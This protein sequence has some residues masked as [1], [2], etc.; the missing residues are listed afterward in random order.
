M[1]DE[2]VRKLALG[3]LFSALVLLAT[4][5]LKVP[6]PVGYIHLG[7]GV[8]FL[9]AMLLGNYAAL[10]AGVGSALSDLLAG[11]PQYIAATFVIKALMGLLAA[12]L[13]RSGKQIRNLF[14]FLA[15][16]ILMVGGYCL[17]ETFLYNW[18]TAVGNI[19]FNLLQGAAGVA[20][21]IAFSLYLPHLKKKL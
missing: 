11:W 5:Q 6:L 3:G 16:E 1:R 4:W 2:R 12:W 21:G 17:F 18:S 13:A 9:S 19:P 14:V 10:I 8:I 7:D 20:L 15:A